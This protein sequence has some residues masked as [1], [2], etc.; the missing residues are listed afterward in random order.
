MKLNQDLARIQRAYI[1][2]QNQG[3]LNSDLVQ[4]IGERMETDKKRQ[5]LS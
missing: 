1:D 2:V 3:G 5:V 4:V